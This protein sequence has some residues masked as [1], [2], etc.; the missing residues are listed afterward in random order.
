M[1]QGSGDLTAYEA[2][3]TGAIKRWRRQNASLVSRVV[4][5]TMGPIG[6]MF[7]K[8][9]PA[10]AIEGALHGGMWLAEQWADKDGVLR[11]LHAESFE[12]LAGYDLERLDRAADNVH[13]WAIAYGGGVGLANGTAGFIAIP[14]GVPAL[15][16][17]AMRTIRKIGLCYGYDGLTEEEKLFI[18]NVMI[19]AGAGGPAEK[20]AALLAL[21]ELQ[22]LIAKETF[23]AMAAKAAGDSLGKVSKE[24][25]VIAVREFGKRIGIQMTRNRL[26]MAVPVVG[27]GVGLL[28]DGNYIRNIGWAARRAYQ[29]RWLRDRG[30]WPEDVAGPVIDGKVEQ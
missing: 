8:I 4:G 12:E 7:R 2:R 1:R 28:V 24:A 20:T 23:K 5:K 16:N 19:L 29:E 15:M 26:L 18:F 10:G 6:W 9:I 3:E 21:R 27:G 17:V 30:R 14:L 13:N 25:F 22:V 11:D